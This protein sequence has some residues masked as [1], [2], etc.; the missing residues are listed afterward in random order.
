MSDN[1]TVAVIFIIFGAIVVTISL[2]LLL[3]RQ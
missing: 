2:L 3:E 1:D